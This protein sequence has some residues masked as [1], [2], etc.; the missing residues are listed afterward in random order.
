MASDVALLDQQERIAIASDLD[1]TFLVEA[2]AGTGKTT[3]LVTRMVA[4]IREEKTPASKMAAITFTRKAAAHLRQK[5]QNE[6]ERSHSTE[7]DPAGKRLL[8]DA[9]KQFDHCYIGTIHSFC[10]QLLRERPVEAGIDP[11][12]KEIEE[13][14]NVILRDSC[15]HECAQRL[16]VEE[17]PLLVEMER[18][19]VSFGNLQATYNV[20]CQYPDVVPM[21]ASIPKPD[22]TCVRTQVDE[23]LKLAERKLPSQPDSKGWDKLQSLLVRALRLRKI[24]DIAEDIEFLRLLEVLDGSSD[25]VQKRWLDPDTAKEMLAFHEELKQ[26]VVS[27]L[28]SQWREYLHPIL[29][30]AVM[31]AVESFAGYRRRNGVLNFQDLLMMARDLLRN[32]PHIRRYF[33]NRYTRLLVDEFQDTDPIQA[34][35]I[36]YLTGDDPEESDWR[37]IRPVPG[38]LFIVGDPKQSIYRFRR[39]DITTYNWVRK[40][41]ENA[42]GKVLKLATNFRSTECICSHV[43]TAFGEIFPDEATEEQAAHVFLYPRRPNTGLVSGVYKL[44]HNTSGIKNNLGVSRVNNPEII[45]VDSEAI[46][47]WIRNALDSGLTVTESEGM[48][49]PL[50]PGDFLI[51]LRGKPF[52]SSYAQAL[53]SLGIPF[54]I[55]GSD[56]FTQSLEIRMLIPFLKSVVDPDDSLSLLA[57]LRGELCGASDSA[58]YLF[59]RAGGRFSYTTNPPEGTDDRIVSAF[60]LLRE[61]REWSRKMPPAAALS[62]ICER[63]GLIAYS[64]VQEF[65]DTRGGNLLKMLSLARGLSSDGSSFA[66]IISNIEELAG[67]ADIEEMGIEP[68]RADAVRLMNL[69]RAKGLE[70]PVVFLAAPIDSTDHKPSYYIDRSTDPPEGHFLITTPHGE[71]HSREVAR[72]IEWDSKATV[73]SRFQMAEEDRLLYVAATRPMNAIVISVYRSESRS[74]PGL[75]GPWCRLLAGVTESLPL[76]D[77][78]F[79]SVGTATTTDLIS[80][81]EKARRGGAARFKTASIP[82]YAVTHVTEVARSQDMAIR[83]AG[84]HGHGAAWGRVVH[85]CLE[86]V[87][88][89]PVIDVRILVA[90][91]LR[92]EEVP[93]AD[94]DVIVQ[95][96]ESVRASDLWN[97]ACAAEKC[98]VEVPFALSVISTDLGLH[99]G[100]AETVLSG[101]IDLVFHDGSS[102]II[103]DYKSDVVDGRLDNLIN[104]YAPQVRCYRKYWEQLTGEPAK[105]ALFFVDSGHVEWL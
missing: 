19:G 36:L 85:S 88:R 66:G 28:L 25:V 100:P 58:I 82:S 33:R 77:S 92:Q 52:L 86:A 51:A 10:A 23:F 13:V 83:G 37:C 97:W 43:N 8:S 95:L 46:A 74:N 89:N 39:A 70:A 17:S 68:G 81:F 40:I 9:L 16:F 32:N 53:E 72:P 91:L 75:H 79:T 11:E 73:E 20:L 57:F 87:I 67:G 56:G 27:P 55:S 47:S 35:L 22:F 31:P 34:E 42:G 64:A 4:L 26:Q 61:A 80:D 18:Y 62:R 44:E 63:L 5:F 41:I 12:F 3:S 84:G 96:V 1:T 24:L 54:E 48:E 14:D 78:T 50:T 103:V 38:S 45:H 2:A 99:D 94:L 69:H 21:V 71:F 49:R 60:N 105:A 15:W 6:L 104:E 76:L 7:K 29:I 101:V 102:W 93:L 90:N 59:K 30:K 65:G 98:F